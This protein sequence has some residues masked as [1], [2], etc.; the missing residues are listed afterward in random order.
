[1]Q[2]RY[3]DHN[4]RYLAILLLCASIVVVVIA[5]NTWHIGSTSSSAPPSLNQE[6][7]VLLVHTS[8]A[9]QKKTTVYRRADSPVVTYFSGMAIDADGAPNA[10]HPSG[11]RG[12]DT[13]SHAGSDGRWWALVVDEEGKPVIQKSGPFKGYYVS[14]TWLSREDDRYPESDPRYWVDATSVPYLAIPKS[15]WKRAGI[16]KGDLAYVINEK[17]GRAS[18]AIVADWGTEETLGEGSI[19]LAEALGFDSSDARTGG[20]E[21]GVTYVVFPGSAGTPRWP[22][23]PAEMSSTAR[24]LFQEWG[25]SDALDDIRARASNH[26][27]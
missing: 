13:L 4:S 3:G 18:A 20:E 16:Q 19:A 9:N 8:P 5:E 10:Y 7:Q 1:M 25:G 11:W 27:E 15:V 6:V 24:R 26:L 17:N 14:Q 12:L 21:S 2:I 22:R 23:D